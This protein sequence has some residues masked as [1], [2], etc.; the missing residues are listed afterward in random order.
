MSLETIIDIILMAQSSNYS[1]HGFRL[2]MR[3]HTLVK[4]TRGALLS[5]WEK[6]SN[7]NYI[8]ALE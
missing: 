7:M 1:K 3:T 2:W 4:P 5:F 8:L 6:R